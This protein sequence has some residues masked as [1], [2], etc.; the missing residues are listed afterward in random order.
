MPGRMAGPGARGRRIGGPP[1]VYCEGSAG[2]I[3]LPVER[4]AAPPPAAP[5]GAPLRWLSAVHGDLRGVG[6]C[7]FLESAHGS[8]AR[9]R[10][11]SLDGGDPRR[12]RRC[13]AAQQLHACV[14][15]SVRL[16]SRAGTAGRG[17]PGDGRP[18]PP[19]GA[20]P[21]CRQDA[22][23]TA[24]P[25]RIPALGDHR[26]TADPLARRRLPGDPGTE[27]GRACRSGAAGRAACTRFFQRPHGVSV[28][29]ARQQYHAAA[30]R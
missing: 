11:R 15:G 23:V 17:R 13:P 6:R 2:C 12:H 14:A 18:S 10:Q 1:I 27:R 24:W 26:N 9:R 19:P 4:L 21:R 25:P 30:E 29:T 7:V 8:S 3:P 22:A 20:S 5:A 16:R 28:S